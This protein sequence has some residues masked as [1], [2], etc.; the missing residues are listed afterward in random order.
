[1]DDEFDRLLR[2]ARA[3]DATRSRASVVALRELAAEEATILGVL[4]DLADRRG[5]VRLIGRGMTRVG[6]VH[7][8]WS[9]GV[10]L[11][12]AGAGAGVEVLVRATA[13]DVVGSPDGCRLHGDERSTPERSWAALVHDRVEP[14]HEVEL[15]VNGVTMRGRMLSIGTEVAVVLGADGTTNY[16]RTDSIDSVVITSDR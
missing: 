12:G 15:A 8:V 16:V 10:V 6:M 13:I 14:S 3:D 11:V 9:G 5:R 7:E 4:H 2:I 1:M